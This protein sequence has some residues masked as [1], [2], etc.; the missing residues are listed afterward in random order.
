MKKSKLVECECHAEYLKIEPIG[1][2]VYISLFVHGDIAKYKESLWT[3]CRDAWRLL[4]KGQYPDNAEICIH[5]EKAKSLGKY[6][7]KL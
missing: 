4:W 2:M 5:A 7:L 6:L 3:R 1:D